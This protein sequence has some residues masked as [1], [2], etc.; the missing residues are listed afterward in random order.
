MSDPSVADPATP[1]EP[2]TPSD[3]ATPCGTTTQAGMPPTTLRGADASAD[4][5]V[6]PGV[7]ERHGFIPSAFQRRTFDPG[8]AGP[9]LLESRIVKA[10]AVLHGSRHE[11][12]SALAAYDDSG[13]WA[14]TG[15]HTCAH[16]AAERL[17]I[18]VGT[19][20]EWLRV[21]HALARLR[22]LDAAMCEGRLSY[23]AVRTLT[24]VMVDHPEHEDELVALGERTRPGDLAAALAGWALA[25]DS[26]EQRGERE[27]RDTFF[28][29]RV[30]PDG[31]GS[32]HIRLPAIDMGRIQAAVDARVMQSRPRVPGEPPP[33]LGQQRARAALELLCGSP[34]GGPLAGRQRPV[35]DTEVIVHVRADACSMHDGTPIADD[36]V[37]S[38]L[39]EAFVRML[40]HDAEN[41]PVNASVRRRHPTTRQKRVVDERDP[42]CVDCGAT[43][44]LEYDH[45]PSFAVTGRTHTDEL[46]RRC[47]R[48]HDRRHSGDGP[49]RGDSSEGLPGPPPSAHPGAPAGPA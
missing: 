22:L 5:L 41:R 1:S 37:A 28:S 4:A 27:R 9:A 46:H 25:H 23:C 20:R 19:A 43:E 18:H 14:F 44:L 26:D 15:A 12:I 34:A 31:M 7:A 48:C 40:V 6:P 11:L 16:W 8:T 17:G 38:L 21:G 2:A 49:V 33:S 3:P 30:E 24:R 42:R 39:D 29:A 45:D 36:A 35:V 13:A 10:A 32:I 47:P